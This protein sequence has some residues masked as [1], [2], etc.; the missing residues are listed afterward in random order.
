M[1]DDGW[2]VAHRADYNGGPWTGGN[3]KF[4]DMTAVASAIKT[5]GAR[6]G[7]WFRPLFT[8]Q[9]E[10]RP[11]ALH[12]ADSA[13][14]T[15]DISRQE[16]L[17]QVAADM[18]RFKQWGFELV[19]YDFSCFDVLQ[20]WGP[21]MG[22][23]Y[24]H[25]PVLFHD[26]TKT[27]AELF[28]QLYRTIKEAAGEMLVMG[29]NVVSHLAAGLIDVMRIGD[30]TSGHAFHRTV[31]MGVNALAFRMPQHNQFYQ[32]DGDCVGI[33][34]DIPWAK[35]LQWLNLLA[36]S[37]T[38]LLVSC[39]FSQLT[40]EQKRDLA[41]AFARNYAQTDLLLPKLPTQGRYP[42]AWQAGAQTYDY[43]WRYNLLE[44]I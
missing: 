34:A 6:P 28:K 25:G 10:L 18:H 2:Q 29:C 3:A 35:N 16:V 14:F 44:P 22:L 36:D 1:I 15:L 43:T 13:A 19:K 30:D 40:A 39:D 12:A 26:Q 21:T 32:V 42:T 4:G 8:N 41:A 7:L 27:T 11:L 31:A 38:P 20:Q 23:T 33:T 9:P 37:G 24:A 17:A 5:R